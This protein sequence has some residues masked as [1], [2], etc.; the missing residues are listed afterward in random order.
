MNAQEIQERV[1]ALAEIAYAA[2]LL[3]IGFVFGR[4]IYDC[5]KP[6]RRRPIQRL[7]TSEEINEDLDA[8]LEEETHG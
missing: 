2:M 7:Y 1:E 5:K 8:W 4:V 6:V 3:A